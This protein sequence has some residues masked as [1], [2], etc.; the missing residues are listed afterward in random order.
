MM[1]A[2]RSESRGDV[3]AQR[4]AVENL[5]CMLHHDRRQRTPK[6]RSDNVLKND[7]CV[8]HASIALSGRMPRP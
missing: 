1:R 3:L 5:W 4:S 8:L 7:V 6:L 2:C